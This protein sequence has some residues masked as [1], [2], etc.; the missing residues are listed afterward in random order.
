MNGKSIEDMV[1]KLGV[2][3]VDEKGI[4]NNTLRK[5]FIEEY[6][7]FDTTTAWECFVD[8]IN[9]IQSVVELHDILTEL[10]AKDWEDILKKYEVIP[11][12]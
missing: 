4:I 5:N 11:N 7:D 8:E 3:L 2:L 10:T 6:K 1:C 9:R 12:E